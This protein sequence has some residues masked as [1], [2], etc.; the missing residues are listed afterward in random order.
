[1]ADQIVNYQCPNC[2]G[3]LKFAAGGG[4]LAC[5]YCGSEYALE[6]IQQLYADK[7]QDAASQGS[8]PEWDVSAAGGEW[9]EEEAANLR[10]F[11][12]PSCGAELICDG[13]TAASSCPYC[14]NPTVVPGRL[15]GQLKP[16]YVLPF[17]LDKNAA[18][19]ALKRYYKGK[20]FL[21]K[22]F[23]EGNHVEDIQGVY[24]PFW[25]FDGQADANI[26]YRGTKVHTDRHGDE[27]V[28][29]TEHYRVVREGSVAFEKIPADGSSKMPDAHMDAVEP[30]NYAELAPFSTAYLP[31]F[32]AD[33]YDLDAEAC[34]ERVN[35]RIRA[36]TLDAMRA[37]ATGYSS[38]NVEHADIRL[39]RGDVK[40]ALMPVW[41]LSTKW[42]EQSFLFAMNGQTGKFVG[43]L[44]V[45]RG[46]FWAW[47][48]GISLPLMA[49]LGLI[50]FIL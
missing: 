49:L 8:D 37:T 4:Q 34:Q 23:R 11:N 3:P 5:E 12:C 45:D 46:L 35:G 14:G 1:M 40:Y 39:T 27:E 31:G 26:R 33:K 21:P 10:A 24:V 50:M 36:S 13:N 20:K 48:A 32:L 44:P 41:M 18:M 7:E 6:L 28:T 19:E 42:R 17:K 25:L 47:F 16:D 43:N 15:T 30:F 29:T 9:S 38:L 2:T 22:S